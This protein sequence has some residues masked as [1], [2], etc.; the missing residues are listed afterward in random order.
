MALFPLYVR[1]LL[2][3]RD[4]PRTRLLRLVSLLLLATA[5]ITLFIPLSWIQPLALGQKLLSGMVMLLLFGAVLWERS[6]HARYDR[7][8]L[9][10]TSLLLTLCA[11]ADMAVELGTL[12]MPVIWLDDTMTLALPL[13]VLVAARV[14]A[15]RY[16]RLRQTAY[17]DPLTGLNSRRFMDEFI[18][19]ELARATRLGHPVAALFIDI[20]LFKRVNDK[21][22]HAAG[23]VVLR[24]IAQRLNGLRREGDFLCRWGGEEFALFMFGQGLPDAQA[25]AERM[26]AAVAAE[27]FAPGHGLPSLPLTISIGVAQLSPG[28]ESLPQLIAATDQALYAAKNAGRNRVMTAGAAANPP[29]APAGSS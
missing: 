22:G 8:K 26:R 4:V 16:Q 19:A 27:P 14:L 23:D 7:G 6:P 5:L 11:G 29:A 28:N 15:N 2:A 13:T 21:Y 3:A 1:F 10:A 25:L 12:N 18:P 17:R 20:D 9:A 24:A